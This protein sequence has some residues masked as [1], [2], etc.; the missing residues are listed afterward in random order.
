MNKS[1][2][3]SARSFKSTISTTSASSAGSRAKSS[4]AR[5]HSSKRS[6]STSSH[7]SGAAASLLSGSAAPLASK[8]QASRNGSVAS[9]DTYSVGSH[10]SNASAASIKSPKSED[11]SVFP[12]RSSSSVSSRRSSRSTPSFQEQMELVAARSQR[13]DWSAARSSPL[14]ITSDA[15]HHSNHSRQS[16][17]SRSSRNSSLSNSRHSLVSAT[18]SRHSSTQPSY[19][20]DQHANSPRGKKASSSLQQQGRTQLESKRFSE[21]IKSFTSAI[22]ACEYDGATNGSKMTMAVLHRFRCEALYELGLYELAANDARKSLKFEQSSTHTDTTALLHSD[23]GSALRSKTLSLLGYSLLRIGID[24]ESAKKCFDESIELIK[25]AIDNDKNVTESAQRSISLDYTKKLLK[26]II[27]ESKTGLDEIHS[28][29]TLKEN[30]KD[31]SRKGHIK[32]LDSILDICPGNVDLHIQKIKHLI[33]QKRW[34]A[35][36]N[37]CEQMAAKASRYCGV[38]I[39]KGDLLDANPFPDMKIEEFDSEYFT[40]TDIVIPQHLRVLP[41]AAAR[42]AAFLLP[43]E[44]LSYYVTSLRLEDR[45][46][47][48]LLV[49]R[50]GALRKAGESG[51]NQKLNETIKHREGGNIFFRKGEFDRAASLYKQCLETELG[52]KMNAV[53][54]YKRGQC[55][56]AMRKYQEATIEFTHAIS[57][58]SMYSDAILQR[59]RCYVRMKDMKKAS[60]NFNR[61]LTLIEGA[62]EHPYPPPYKGSDCFFDMPGD[63]TYRKVESVKAEMRLHKISPDTNSN[64]QHNNIQ[65]DS[66]FIRT[67][68]T[69]FTELFCKKGVTNQVVASKQ[70]TTREYSREYAS[71]GNGRTTTLRA[72]DENLRSSLNNRSTKIVRFLGDPP[73][74]APTISSSS[75]AFQSRSVFQSGMEP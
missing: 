72:D 44:V 52:G 55:F 23:K 50:S 13:P 53:L 61:Y 59:A 1:L 18:S 20:A 73:S 37:H 42:E 8:S 68:N 10:K 33:K 34:F 16:C 9:Y 36:S 35:V 67:L 24:L 4:C 22:L 30:L 74:H 17:R 5:R 31:S 28:Y 64:Q 2:G 65:S 75:A 12:R 27:D 25:E 46:D 56:Y 57:I 38:G 40:R 62:R 47:A 29:E 49:C 54:H 11:D 66:S 32:D 15:S 58:H 39:F 51:D 60:A 71:P 43:K 14:S 19:H 63:I 21:A 48:A 45:Y 69:T 70:P 26:T 7:E 41:T 3:S 6:S